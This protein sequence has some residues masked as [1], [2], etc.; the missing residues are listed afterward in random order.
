VVVSVAAP[1]Y[2]ASGLVSS[3]KFDTFN[4]FGADDQ[5]GIVR[6]LRSQVQVQYVFAP[7]APTLANVTV[8]VDVPDQRVNGGAAA[9]LSGS[10]WAVLG[11]AVHVG[12]VWRYAFVWSGSLAAGGSTSTLDYKVPLNPLSTGPVTITGAATAPGTAPASASASYVI[13]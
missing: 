5:G 2:A 6:S 8:T 7:G 10:G 1:A 4:L 9:I 12:A 11:S 13:P 3:L